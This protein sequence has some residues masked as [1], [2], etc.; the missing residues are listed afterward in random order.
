MKNAV[1]NI[2]GEIFPPSETSSRAKISVFDRGYLYGDSLYEVVRTYQG[3]FFLMDDHLQR[4]MKSAELCHMKLAQTP[5]QF[6]NE[7]E[8][9]FETFK[10]LPGNQNT[11][12][13]V[14]LIVSRG[15][16]RIG[17]G[18]S[19]LTTS[20]Q[21]TIIIQPVE[22][23]TPAEFETGM[24]LQISK[25]LRNHPR[26][27]D[28]AMKSGN[29]LNSLLAYLEAA[30]DT[31]PKTGQ[32]RFNDALLQNGDG[33]ITEGTTFNIFYVKR[34]I[35]V[36]SPLDI[37]IL[38]GITRRKVIQLAESAEIPVRE[39]RFPGSRLHEADEVF[40][41]SSI[42]EV[43]PVTEID[44]RRIS[45]GTPGPITRK[46]A[47]LYQKSILDASYVGPV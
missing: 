15:T 1:I 2:N 19:C 27:L 18:L 14:R 34:G 46:L 35:V 45:K 42:R 32:P 8:R 3:Q 41:S 38:D 12:A 21:Y 44:G 24:R 39:V 20:S 4:L 25:R 36:T 33:H 16:G 31:H 28:P 47:Q 5:T 6:E 29:Y 7:I 13:Y 11:D 43:F 30:S 9:T 37:G 17:F 40:I 23:P 10:A 26:A 22:A